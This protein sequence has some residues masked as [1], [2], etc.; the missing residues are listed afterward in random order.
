VTVS[1]TRSSPRHSLSGVSVDLPPYG[2]RCWTDDGL[3]MSL[4]D[5]KKYY[6]KCG[7]YEYTEEK[8]GAVK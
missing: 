1:S 7:D 2:W 8:K 4:S 5:D 6:A 3:V